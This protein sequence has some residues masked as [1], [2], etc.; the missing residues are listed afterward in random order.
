MSVVKVP[1][2]GG[3]HDG[4]QM[5]AFASDDGRISSNSIHLL[6]HRGAY[7]ISLLNKRWLYKWFQEDGTK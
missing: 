6:E 2:F 5:H 4:E 7:A 1:F 3:P